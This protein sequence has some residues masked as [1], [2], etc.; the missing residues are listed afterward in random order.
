MPLAGASADSISHSLWLG[1]VNEMALVLYVYLPH[2]R[3]EEESCLT[4]SFHCPK[5]AFLKQPRPLIIALQY[6]INSFTT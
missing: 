1:F 3:D 2:N 6:Y 5:N 4:V